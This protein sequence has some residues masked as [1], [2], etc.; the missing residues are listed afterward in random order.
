LNGER[1]KSVV[2]SSTIA[3]DGTLRV[4]EEIAKIV[5]L[6]PGSMIQVRL[7]PRELS[8]RL[9]DLGVTEME[10]NRIGAVQLSSRD[11]VVGFLLTEGALRTTKVVG[12][13]RR[14]TRKG[15]R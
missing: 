12:G 8:D 1:Q 6:G 14:R 9:K 11:K 10:I 2:F 13:A 15:Q 4:P 3:D 5:G 7:T